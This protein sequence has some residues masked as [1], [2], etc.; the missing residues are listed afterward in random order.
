M[1]DTSC[2][3]KPTMTVLAAGLSLFAAT[4]N[5]GG[6]GRNG[7]RAD[8]GDPLM[9][10]PQLGG[11]EFTD[12]TVL[13]QH[14]VT[15][16]RWYV[17][18]QSGMIWTSLNADD[19]VREPFAD[20][21]DRV[22]SEADEAGLLGIAFHPWFAQNGQVFVSYT[23]ASATAP[24]KLESRISRF[25]SPDKGK[26]LDPSSEKVLLRID[27]PFLNHNGGHIAFGPDELLYIAMGDGGSA[28]DPMGNGQNPNTL[29]G[30]VL[31]ID[32]DGGDPFKIPAD[33]PFA[34][35]GGRPEIYALGLRN[36]WQFS[37]DSKSG[38]LWL[39]DVGQDKFE[40]IDIIEKGGNYGWAV[41]EASH[42]ATEATCARGAMKDPVAEYSQE[43]GVSVIG[44]FVYH[45]KALP[46]LAGHYLFSDFASGNLWA[47]KQGRGVVRDPAPLMKLGIHPT[48]FAQA[49]DGEL[50]IADFTSG[51]I[52]QL[53]P[54][55]DS[56]PAPDSES[57]PQPAP[58][59][60]SKEVLTFTTLWNQVLSVR[61]EPCHTRR[62]LGGFHI[63][64]ETSAENL[65][66]Q[67]ATSDACDGRIRVVPGDPDGSMVLSKIT[68][69]NLCGPLMPLD[70]DMPAEEIELVRKWI[71]DG[72]LP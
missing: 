64:F 21:R 65:I 60:D 35:G 26:T 46:A 45:G 19:A 68:G 66:N 71:A 30:K 70:G 15:P 61:C 38:D 50:Y 62:A 29:L 24:A 40:E 43:M 59:S 69:D 9:L 51:K 44:G 58:D 7:E 36:P 2:M 11:Q 8:C 31:R 48:T 32:V 54:A 1:H 28:N 25:V 39:G 52:F 47:I 57:I 34:G 10:V 41:R 16:T 20:L 14:P 22:S 4:C 33:N 49:A 5:G 18:E 6:N 63:P 42:C 17:G 56:C 37:F 55:G 12:P 3:P 13:V 72:A 27:Q 53:A 23:A 67:P